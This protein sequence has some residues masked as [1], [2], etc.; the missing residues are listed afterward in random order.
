MP[1]MQK[2]T[3]TRSR[4]GWLQK[5]TD[6][7]SRNGWLQKSTDTR[8]RNGWLQKST[9]TRSRNGWL[10]KS[11]DTRSRNGWLQKSTY[12]RSRNGWLQKS[13]DTRSRNG[14]LQKSTDTR[15]R[16][17]WLQKSTDTR[18]RNGWCPQTLGHVMGGCKVQ[19][20]KG[21]YDWRHNSV[22]PRTTKE[23]GRPILKYG[24]M[25]GTKIQMWG[26]SRVLEVFQCVF[27][28]KAGEFIGHCLKFKNL[29]NFTLTGVKMSP[30]FPKSCI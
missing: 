5:S 4:N 13:T 24:E 2:S 26:I 30:K 19:L 7:R 3:D 6:T 28:A 17:G 29:Q 15:S 20:E 8:S 25:W 9:D 18:S 27:F 1:I 16:N 23:N 21:R 11:T 14:W 12:T 22:L 10:Q